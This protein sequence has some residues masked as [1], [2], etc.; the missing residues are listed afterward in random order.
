LSASEITDDFKKLGATI[1]IGNHKAEN[2]PQNADMIV[3]SP[4]VEKTNPELKEAFKIKDAGGK[5]QIKSYPE[6]LGELV[7]KYFTVAV[8]GAHGKSTT[9]SMLALVLIKAGLDPTVIVGT[10]LKEFRNSNFR[11]GK[12]K[13]LVI[14]ACEYEDAFLNYW[15]K[16]ITITNIDKEHLDYFKNFRNVLKSFKTYISHLGKDGV[17]VYNADDKNTSK[18]KPQVAKLQIKNRKYSIKQKDASEIKKI[19]KVPGTHNIYNALAVLETARVLG[20]DDKITFKALSEFT[21]TWRRFE[22]SE[23]ETKN[24]KL[25]IDADYGHHPNEVKATLQA[26]REKYPD[27][28]IWCVFQPHQY[29]RTFNLFKDFVSVFKKAKVDKIIIADVYSVA[30]RE[31]DEIRNKVNSEKL[32]RAVKKESVIY[33]KD[34]DLENYLFE[35]LK[36][37]DVL[38]VMGAGNIYK[39]VEKIKQRAN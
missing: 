7:K 9:T 22:E 36:S 12:S 28:T 11:M 19:L 13:Y 4:A 5:I 24:V 29:Q 39:L 20:V 32:V 21:G 2:I 15:P 26:V 6:A 30:G 35:N 37:T 31:T 25:N 34:G 3:Y 27:K 16:I 14:E 38:L 33:K 10:K 17:L 18:I 1:S 23:L 8:S